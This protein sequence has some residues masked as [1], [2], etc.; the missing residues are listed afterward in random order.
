M[1]SSGT[2]LVIFFRGTILA[3]VGHNSSLGETSSDLGGARP[4][5]A[6]CGAGPVW[7][8]S[9]SHFFNKTAFEQ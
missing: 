1:Q 6:P 3:W 8:S 7:G 4:R 9:S 5:N 2:G